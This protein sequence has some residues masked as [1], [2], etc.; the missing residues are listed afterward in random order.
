MAK[1]L[2]PASA[3]LTGPPFRDGRH[4]FIVHTKHPCYCRWDDGKPLYINP[5]RPFWRIRGNH[6][7]LFETSAGEIPERMSR[8]DPL[9][10]VISPRVLILTQTTAVRH[11]GQIR[12]NPPRFWIA[13]GRFLSAVPAISKSSLLMQVFFVLGPSLGWQVSDQN[14][15]ENKNHA[16]RDLEPSAS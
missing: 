13:L 2:K 1:Q 4:R 3:G 7:F 9:C 6:N 15:S 14:H 8:Q 11:N 16:R 10:R 12:G 5:V